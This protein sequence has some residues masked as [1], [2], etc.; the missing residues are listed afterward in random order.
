MATAMPFPTVES[1]IKKIA[2]L[3]SLEESR[4]ADVLE[5]VLGVT[6]DDIGLQLLDSYVTSQ[7]VLY[8][9]LKGQGCFSEVPVLRL[10]VVVSILKG[11]D[12]FA[13]KEGPVVTKEPTAEVSPTSEGQALAAMIETMKNPEQM[14][15][16][17]LLEKYIKTKDY[18]LEQELNRRSG[19]Q[20]FVIL[21]EGTE[22]GHEEI[23]LEPTLDLLKKTRKRTNPSMLPHPSD[24][25]RV[26]QIYRITQL[27]PDDQIVSLCPFCDGVMHDDYCGECEADWAGV[28]DEERAYVRLIAEESN[29]FRK[30]G[31]SDRRAALV[32]AKHGL[33]DLRKTW[34]S[35]SIKFRELKTLGELPKLKKLR[36]H[37]VARVKDPF[38]VRDN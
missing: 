9:S 15:D 20:Y 3:L 27:N 36:Q 2:E 37:P 12:P 6:Q 22:K 5:N 21:K 16:Q 10:R 30:D 29:S 33:E 17:E 35:V 31:H 1:R 11:I 24:R 23:D 14:S 38:H 4:V 13:K 7:D 26:V 25:T 18:T 34:P 28:G 32:S 19:G 8:D